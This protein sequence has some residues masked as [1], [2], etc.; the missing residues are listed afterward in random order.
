MP[1]AYGDNEVRGGG[2]APPPTPPTPASPSL[3]REPAE[4]KLPWRVLRGKELEEEEKKKTRGE[5]MNSYMPREESAC[6]LNCV[7]WGQPCIADS[8]EYSQP[9]SI[10]LSLDDVSNPDFY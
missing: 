8:S 1:R 9:C 7:F 10:Y 5:M 3:P 6:C 2:Y 4:G